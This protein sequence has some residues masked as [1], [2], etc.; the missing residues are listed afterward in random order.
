MKRLSTIICSAAILLAACNNESKKTEET[1]GKTDTMTA[2]TAE[3]APETY[4]MPDSATAMKNW[5]DYA[6]PGDV[7]KMMA[8]WNGTWT[9][10][11]TMWETPE[12][13]PTKAT[14]KTV[15]KMIM[16]GRYQVSSHSG[17]MMGMPFE[18][19]GTMGYDNAQKIF[20]STWID[21]MGTGVSTLKG[22]WDA[23]SKSITLTGKM[24]DPSAGNG[25]EHN[26]REVLKIIDD[27]TQLLEMYYA[28]PD[29]K[30]FKNMEIRFTRKK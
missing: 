23:A 19:Q 22:P 17:E 15:N 12:K 5:M 30:E 14:I 20:I 6:T 24:V 28:G 4:T 29:G 9:G 11:M 26:M 25:R 7:Q 1:A 16:D 3:K 8:S 18:G 10:E 13:P 21:N 27:N 2:A